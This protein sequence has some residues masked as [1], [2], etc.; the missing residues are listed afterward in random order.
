MPLPGTRRAVKRAVISA[1]QGA[2]TAVVAAVP[3]KKIR[4]LNLWVTS[5]FALTHTW[6]SAS[7][8]LTGAMSVTAGFGYA[9]VADIVGHL[10]TAAGEALNLTVSGGSILVGGMLTYV[11]E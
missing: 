9:G 1:P 3:G 2:T 7:T 5:G 11:E 10:V 4:V 8:A 6:K